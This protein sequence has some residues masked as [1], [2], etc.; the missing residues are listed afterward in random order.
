M[1]L[2]NFE[3]SGPMPK[4]EKKSL[5]IFL[6]IG[7]LVGTVALG[8]TL[9]AS[10]NLNDSGPVE[11][12]QGVTQTTSCDSEV[13]VTP[14]SSFVNSDGG[15]DFKFSAITLSDLDGTDQAESSEGCAGKTF[16]IKA[17]DSYGV[18][19]QPSY[20]ISV[21]SNGNFSSPSGEGTATNEGSE[22]SS[23]TL[24]F[25][26]DILTS[27]ESVYRITI[28][29]EESAEVTPTGYE[30][31][32]VGPGGGIVF[33]VADEPF[34]CGF[35]LSLFC[36]YL[37]VAPN[38]WYDNDN[39]PARTWSAVSNWE[40]SV[41]GAG[42]TAI[43]TGYANS[44]AIASQAGNDTTNSAAPEATAYTGGDQVDWYLPSKDELDS[45][46]A[47]KEIVGGF[48]TGN[49]YWSSSE[50][51]NEGAWNQNFGS[52]EQGPNGKFDARAVRPIR[53]F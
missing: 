26:G 14:I 19:L 51:S 18:Q 46:Y 4:G 45:L 49:N 9:A 39:D 5:K 52:G 50:Y 22:T 16:T 24:T 53:A 21:D 3:P 8:S 20:E 6:G 32:N 42:R 17:Y 15:G 44:A 27:A 2:L 25:F 10:I 36:Q 11:F 29:S 40:T 47:Q 23:V 33:Y 12:G 7:L 43:G 48:T 31:G 37:E 28:E 41:E 38:G 1:S 34:A 13:E 35:D 30:V